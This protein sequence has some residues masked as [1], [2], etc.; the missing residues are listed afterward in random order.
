MKYFASIFAFLLIVACFGVALIGDTPTATAEEVGADMAA[1]RAYYYPSAY[2]STSDT[3]TNAE[4]DTLT[5]SANLV[6]PWGVKL[7]AVVANLSG[8]T[9]MNII[10]QGSLDLTTSKTWYPIDTVAVAGA[11]TY[12]WED[13]YVPE[14][15]HRFI[16]DGSGAQSSTYAVRAVYKYPE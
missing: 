15:A 5:V 9:A 12:T 2:T 3:I 6:S 10:V 1:A 16:I 8:T 4:N 7:V 14:V 11:G 13:S